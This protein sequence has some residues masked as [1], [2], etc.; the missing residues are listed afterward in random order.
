MII[1]RSMRSTLSRSRT[2]ASGSDTTLAPAP[3]TCTRSTGRCQE[4]MPSRLCTQTCLPATA[5]G[6]GRFTYVQPGCR[7]II[8]MILTKVLDPAC[9]RAR[10]DG[11][12]QAPVHQATSD[13]G[14]EV[15][16]AAP[17]PQDF[18]EEDLQ[19][20]PAVDICLKRL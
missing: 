7:K 5:L 16:P 4:R 3:T 18:D 12:H 8:G 2:S 14:P 10:E 20:H 6:S 13:Q 19:C 9:R 17:C 11:R 1:R 15:P